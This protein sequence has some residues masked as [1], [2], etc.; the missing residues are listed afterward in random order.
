MSLYVNHEKGTIGISIVNSYG[1]ETYK[2]S[3]GLYFNQDSN[4][5]EKK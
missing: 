1:K 2:Q 5:K 3:L 4:L